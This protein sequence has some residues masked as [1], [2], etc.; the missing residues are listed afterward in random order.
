MYP[1]GLRGKASFLTVKARLC[2]PEGLE[3]RHFI[4]SP[5]ERERWRAAGAWGEGAWDFA[6]HKSPSP[7]GQTGEGLFEKCTTDFAPHPLLGRE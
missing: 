2:P 4:T 6:R 7:S 3:G 5:T 1:C